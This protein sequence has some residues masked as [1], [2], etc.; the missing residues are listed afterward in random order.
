[1]C[2]LHKKGNSN[3]RKFLI[4]S[5]LLNSGGLRFADHHFC[6]R[7]LLDV[8]DCYN[9]LLDVVENFHRTGR[10]MSPLAFIK[11]LYKTN[12]Q[13]ASEVKFNSSKVS[14]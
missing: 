9:F 11:G 7:F 4:F 6:S 3:N 8:V 13:V 12:V 1:M 10:Y 5:L 2:V 14:E